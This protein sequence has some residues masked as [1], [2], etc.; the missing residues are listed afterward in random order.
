MTRIRV[1]GSVFSGLG[2]GGFYV[3]IYAKQFRNTLGFTPYPGTLNI[4]INGD[5]SSVRRC[6][7]E[8]GV[9]VEPPGIP[10][11]KLGA[12]R[13]YPAWLRGVEVYIV[14]PDITV[15]RYDVIEV[16]AKTYL[17]GLLGLRDGDEVEVEI[18]CGQVRAPD[19]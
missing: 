18:E 7:E 6:L 1:R 14:R 10:G 16:I 19:T 15:Y 9:R 17:R 12:V 8:G 4:R 3:S 5:P 11:V 13:V 2:E